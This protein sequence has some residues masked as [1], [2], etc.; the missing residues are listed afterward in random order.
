VEAEGIMHGR[1]A[2]RLTAVLRRN[3]PSEL[4][5]VEWSGVQ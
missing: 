5:V 2:A 4:V 1:V 3:S